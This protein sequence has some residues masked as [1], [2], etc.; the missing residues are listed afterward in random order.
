[1]GRSG[2]E[3]NDKPVMELQIVC[4]DGKKVG[5]LSQR[6]EGELLWI[7]AVLR[8]ALDV[9]AEPPARP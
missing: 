6:N 2:M 1:L 4:K 5:F 7:A 8:Q 9:R 3:V